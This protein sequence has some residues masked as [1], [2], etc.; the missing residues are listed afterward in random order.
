MSPYRIQAT[1]PPKKTIP[2]E[3]RLRE[4]FA[5]WCM[6]LVPAWGLAFLP[7]TYMLCCVLNSVAWG[8]AI[9]YGLLII[10]GGYILTHWLPRES[11]HWSWP[12]AYRFARFNKTPWTG[13][14]QAVWLV[15]LFNADGY[16]EYPYDD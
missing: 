8:F 4:R 10:G 6:I 15:N 7:I 1:T 16:G 2:D 13:V 3:R 11:L 14:T 12:V 9:T 5:A